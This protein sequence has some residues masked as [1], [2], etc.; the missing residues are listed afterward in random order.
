MPLTQ[1]WLC[2]LSPDEV[3][4]S[5]NL[6]PR[7]PTMNGMK[8]EGRAAW[9]MTVKKRRVNAHPSPIALGRKPRMSSHEVT[10]CHQSVFSSRSVISLREVISICS[11]KCSNAFVR[12]AAGTVENCMKITRRKT[13]LE[14]ICLVSA[15]V[16]LERILRI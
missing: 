7:G 12:A 5:D 4:V 16:F 13:L 10:F 11:P 9:T 8:D 6:G 15:R 14:H 2:P 3:A 1:N